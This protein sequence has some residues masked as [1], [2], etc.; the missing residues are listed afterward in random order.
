MTLLSPLDPATSALLLM[1]FQQ[2]ILAN[3]LPPE[4]ATSVLGNATRLLELARCKAMPVIHVM[5]CFRPG[6]PE[7]N[8]TNRVFSRIKQNGLFV[9]GAAG[10]A[11]HPQLQPLAGEPVVHKHR[12]GAFSGTDLQT[13][14]RASQVDTLLIAGVATSGVVLSTVRHAADQDYRLVVVADGCADPAGRGGEHQRGGCS[15]GVRPARTA[16]GRW[17]TQ[18]A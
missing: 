10:T 3:N 6:H 15:A 2:D 12:V 18:G 4:Q 11:I 1:D 8:A 16:S 14:L 5:V 17:R 7:I 9:L 13:L